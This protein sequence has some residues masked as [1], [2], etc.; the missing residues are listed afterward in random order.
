MDANETLF[1]VDEFNNHVVWML[2]KN[3]V[4]VTLLAGTIQSF[5]SSAN[6]FNYPQDVYLD[7]YRNMYVSDC[8]GYRV[9][10]FINGSKI[11]VTVAGVNASSGTA[12]NQFGGLRYFWFDPTETYMYVAD[13]ANH[14]IM[15]Y[16]KNSTSGN[17]GVVVAGGNGPGN[18][19]TKLNYPWGIYSFPSVTNDLYIT[20]YYGHS[21]VRWTPGASS[22]T[23]V[24]GTPGLPGSNASLLNSPMGI[25][26]DADLNMYVLDYS[27]HRVQMFCYNSQVGVTIA[28][29]GI[30][31][32]S[33][34]QL[35]S[36]RSILF[37]SSM[38][39]YISDSGN[40]RIQKFSK[41]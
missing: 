39:M 15:R 34:T 41:I 24:A 18:G 28:G 1:L 16:L 22:G 14:R 6:Q 8:Y 4:N 25:K 31:G 19:N 36:P 5:G 30:S 40:N 10:K 35:N 3:A 32:S 38:N 2:P 26:L 23:I 17:D 29:T 7:S 20:N 12:L 11:G 27:N 21:V 9:Q 33:A 37:D 13:S